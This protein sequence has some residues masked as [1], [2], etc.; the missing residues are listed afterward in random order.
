MQDP[1]ELCACGSGKKYKFCCRESVIQ[2]AEEVAKADSKQGAENLA[3]Y[4]Q[5]LAKQGVRLPWQFDVN[6]LGYDVDNTG[7]WASSEMGNA[8]SESS[9]VAVEPK[10]WKKQLLKNWK[11]IKNV[12]Q[13]NRRIMWSRNVSIFISLFIS[14]SYYYNYNEIIRFLI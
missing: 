14:W 2:A 9:K 7:Q 4:T 5:E 6:S 10:I 13:C 8:A 11:I 1:Y 3:D 12:L